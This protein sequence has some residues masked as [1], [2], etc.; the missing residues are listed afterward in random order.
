MGPSRPKS[1]MLTDVE[2][3]IVVAFRRHTLLP[4]DD[5]VG[6]LREGIPKLTRSA[7]HHCLQRVPASRDCPETKSE[8]PSAVAPLKPRS[9]TCTGCA[10]PRASFTRFLVID[11]PTKRTN[12]LDE[13]C[14][15]LTQTNQMV[16][17]VNDLVRYISTALNDGAVETGT[18]WKEWI[19]RAQGISLTRLRSRAR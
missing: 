11:R 18:G 6:C 9:A 3:A 14:S 10:G 1:A 7:L 5:V 4:L 15:D 2:E 17:P 8:R 16:I 19:L 13:C 12:Q